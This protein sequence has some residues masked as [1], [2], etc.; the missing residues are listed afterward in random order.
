MNAM[1]VWNFCISST[2]CSHQRPFS[3]LF[4][5]HRLSLFKRKMQ[6]ICALISSAPPCNRLN[7]SIA[8]SP[9]PIA[10]DLFTTKQIQT[11]NIEYLKRSRNVC[12]QRAPARPNK[13]YFFVIVISWVCLGLWTMLWI[14][15]LAE[16]RLQPNRR[17][18]YRR[19]QTE[20]VY[21]RVIS[22]SNRRLIAFYDDKL[23]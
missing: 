22:A 4:I 15:Y 7:V 19:T 10:F 14:L 5:K 17:I 1:R 23:L 16:T 9:H 2:L 13:L 8:G 11:K 18:E 6:I 3:L 21:S 20:V 12:F